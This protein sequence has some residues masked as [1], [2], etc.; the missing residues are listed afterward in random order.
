ME[1]Y[2]LALQP[3]LLAGLFL[4][5]Y[6]IGLCVRNIYFVWIVVAISTMYLLSCVL[7]ANFSYPFICSHNNPLFN[8]LISGQNI[9]NDMAVL[10][11]NTKMNL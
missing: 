11:Y 8:D 3:L 5:A 4:R 10:I 7:N 1:I 6:S 2:C 9:L